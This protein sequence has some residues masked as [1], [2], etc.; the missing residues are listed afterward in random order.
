M[1]HRKERKDRKKT[2]KLLK[3]SL[4]DNDKA[5]KARKLLSRHHG[6]QPPRRAEEMAP[7]D[8]GDMWTCETCGYYQ[9]GGSSWCR[10]SRCAGRRNYQSGGWKPDHSRGRS[11]K[12]GGKN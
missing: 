9:P 10:T 2:R 6:S 5:E 12:S 4:E 8:W 1:G 7:T 3:G 11:P